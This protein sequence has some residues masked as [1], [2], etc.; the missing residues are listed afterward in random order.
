MT[1]H[2]QTSCLSVFANF[3]GLVFKEWSAFN[4]EV[5]FVQLKLHYLTRSAKP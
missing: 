2:T 5:Q 1:K 3:V 4:S